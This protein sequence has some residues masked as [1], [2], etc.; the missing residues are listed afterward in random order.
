MVI[1]MFRKNDVTVKQM[2]LFS[3]ESTWPDYK[4]KRIKEGWPEIFRTQIMPNID[5]EPY[6]VLYSEKGSRPNT[7]VNILVSILI[8]KSLLGYS[9]ERMIDGVLFDEQVQYALGTLDYAVQPISKNMISNFRM[10]IF[11]YEK[12][13]GI[14]LFADTLKKINDNLLK[15]TEI[16]TS[17]KRADSL[18]ISSSCKNMT[19]TE[20][21]YKVNELFIKL[22]DKKEKKISKKYINYLKKDNEVEVLYKTVETEISGKLTMLL[23]ESID[24]YE[25]YKDD[26]ELNN[27]EQ[28]NNLKR[29]INDQYDNNKKGPKNGKEIKPTSMQTPFDKDA[30]YRFKY[31]GNKGYVGNVVEAVDNKKKLSLITS[32]DIAPNVKSDAEFM[33]EMIE[34]KKE[35]VEETIVVDAAYYSNDLR[36]LAE[37]NN[38]KIHPTD[39]TGSK[40]IEITNL[41]EFK[42]NENNMIEKCPLGKLAK[43]SKYDEKRNMIYADFEKEECVNCRCQNNCVVKILKT[44]AKLTKSLNQIERAKLMAERNTEEYK[45]IS[46]IRSGIEGIPSVLRRKYNIDN[47]GSK[48]LPY[49][50]MVYS[51]SLISINI[52]RIVKYGNKILKEKDNHSIFPR[53]LLSILKL[54]KIQLYTC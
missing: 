54:L 40:E 41:S 7:P 48:G 52:K 19:R 49:L 22:L 26:K 51:A 42:I 38:V 12:E 10:K 24:L 25:T 31:K 11:N 36:F 46:H 17:L 33:K 44:K 14:N 5:E 39:L 1:K 20:L 29:L 45:E 21:I 16:D 43:I 9:D 8:I 4:L 3:K 13:T 35:D 28:F 53:L 15:M 18:M 47:R 2:N 32:W 37:E 23:N 30:T 34:G 50:C 27:T 6:V